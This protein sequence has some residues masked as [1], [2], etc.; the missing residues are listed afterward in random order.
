MGIFLSF[1]PWIAFW[2]LSGNGRYQI[3]SLV[4]VC[5]V[6]VLNIRDLGKGKVKI[7]DLGTLIFFIVLTIISFTTEAIWIDHYSAPLSDSAMFLIVLISLV[8]HKPFTLQYAYERVDK[9]FWNTPGFYK[10]NLTISVVWCIAFAVNAVLSFLYVK[11]P[12]L[13]DWIIHIL[14][15]IAAIK[16]TAWYPEYVKAKAGKQQN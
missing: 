15:L 13:I 14:V 11:H 12:Y 1:L 2:I 10:T 9:Q 7:L 4:A 3:A 6:I 8:M 16:F 5:V